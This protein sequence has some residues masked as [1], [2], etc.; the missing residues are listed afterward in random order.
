M[1]HYRLQLRSRQ[2]QVDRDAGEPKDVP[3]VSAAGVREHD[4]GVELGS[5]HFFK[6]P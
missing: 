1:R 2:E 4:F 3:H 5:A 6:H